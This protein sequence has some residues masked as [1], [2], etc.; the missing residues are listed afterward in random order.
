[1]KTISHNLSSR[2]CISSSQ[3]AL[4]V[5]SKFTGK[6]FESKSKFWY[7]ICLICYSRRPL[8]AVKC[9]SWKGSGIRRWL[10]NVDYVIYDWCWN[11]LVFERRSH[12]IS[13]LSKIT[14]L[15]QEQNFVSNIFLNQKVQK[16]FLKNGTILQ[17]HDFSKV[18]ISHWIWLFK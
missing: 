14:H 11:V 7:E 13:D 16:I 6:F 12:E 9:Y 15:I 4:A 8:K 18:V 10:K 3:Y 1:M 5:R 2:Y 17:H